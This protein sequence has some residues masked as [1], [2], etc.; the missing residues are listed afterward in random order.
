VDFSAFLY[1][2]KCGYGTRDAATHGDHHLCVEAL[3]PRLDWI[4][5][6]GESGPGARP[7]H[8][9]WFRSIRDQ[10][11]VAG[12]AHFFKQWGEFQ[13]V[14]CADSFTDNITPSVLFEAQP[15]RTVR[16]SP[17]GQ[18]DSGDIYRPDDHS[19]FMERVG[20]HA[21]GRL[22]DGV[23]HNQLPQ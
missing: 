12:T 6:G 9:D 2:P 20:K 5:S 8:P 23:E 19:W 4:I 10:C 16:V 13:P 3:P 7:A 14:G 18:V 22:L 1:C 11:K 21:A 17:T 15:D